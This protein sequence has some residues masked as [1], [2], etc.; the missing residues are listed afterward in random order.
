MANSIRNLWPRLTSWNNLL[1]AYAK[2][3]R[4]KRS[5]PEAAAFDFAWEEHLLGLQRELI[6]GTYRPGEYHN[7][8][9]YNPKRRKISAAPFRDRVVH[10][11][12][13]RVL[14]PFYERRFLYD[15]Y[16]CRRHKG[17][18][19][20]IDRAE[21][22]L[23]RHRYYLKTDLVKFFPNVDH[24]ALLDLLSRRIRDARLMELIRLL[25]ASGAGVLADEATQE[26]FPGDDLFAL[27][28]PKGLPIGNLTSQFFANVLLD[29]IDH[30]I[31]EELRVPGYI[32]YAD[33]LLLFGDDKRQLW[34]W[35]DAVA[36]RLEPLRFRL[37][38]GKTQVRPCEAGLKFLGM[39][40]DRRGRRLPQSALLA[41]NGRLRRLRW[42]F[43]HG[44]VDAVD[45][46][47]SLAA[48]RA[49]AGGAN[50]T[51]IAQVLIRRA[52]FCRPAVE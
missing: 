47:R 51:G 2:C 9:V 52:R 5:R 35:R 48:W 41:F 33:D 6:A 28:R 23:H 21:R 17:T 25:V 14:E 22:Y 13:V 10:H 30:F 42:E 27:L 50:S 37:H 7:F 16:A 32:R 31:K 43:A 19:R 15:S 39:K 49:H 24:G 8:Y 12:V 26:F 11:A 1:T 3:R 4:K 18:H 46:R 34:Q 38:A 45:V 36:E 40:L 29:P 44:L 20:A